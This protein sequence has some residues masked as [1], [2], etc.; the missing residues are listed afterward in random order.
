MKKL[1][2]GLMA[3]VL[4]VTLVGCGNQG[5]AGPSGSLEEI[6]ESMYEQKPVEFAVGTV[7][8][9]I[10]NDNAMLLSYTGLAS[11]ELIEEV[12]VSES[13]MG[14]QAYSIVL[15]RVKDASDTAS[16]AEEMKAGIDPRKWICVEADDMQVVAAN[17]VVLLA[18]MSSEF[19][20]MITSQDFVDMFRELSGGLDIEL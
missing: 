4:M 18:M 14:S 13:M 7:P 12:L 5:V 9:D 6:V 15:V 19:S 16:V 17:D 1:V 11:N 8:M 3:F 20:E 2:K 10:M